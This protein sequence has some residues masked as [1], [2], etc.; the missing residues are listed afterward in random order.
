[1]SIKNTQDHVE[2]ICQQGCTFA[3]QQI[4]LLID[5]SDP[6]QQEILEELKSLM[7]VYDDKDC[8]QS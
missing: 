7:A 4:K 6:Q 1:M 5:S 3:K 8:R 2:Q